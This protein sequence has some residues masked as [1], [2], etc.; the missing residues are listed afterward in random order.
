MDHPFVTRRA[1]LKRAEEA[2]VILDDVRVLCDIAPVDGGRL[3]SRCEAEITDPT[4]RAAVRRHS[5]RLG[6]LLRDL[7]AACTAL[8]VAPAGTA[9]KHDPEWGSFLANGGAT[10]P[11]V[12]LNLLEDL[13]A[14]FLAKR[15]EVGAVEKDDDVSSYSDYSDSRTESGDSSGSYDDDDDDDDGH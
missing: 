1:E 8:S 14:G 11:P 3:R 9:T 2:L 6:M 4:V 7:D 13:R 10:E 15:D 12:P 5:D